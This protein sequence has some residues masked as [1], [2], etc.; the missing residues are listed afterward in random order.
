MRQWLDRFTDGRART[1]TIGVGAVLALALAGA[2]SAAAA[3][4]V[5]ENY[6]PFANCPVNDK[7]VDLCIVATTTSGEFAMGSKTVHIESP[8]VLEGGI[9][10]NGGTQELV[11]PTSGHTLESPPMKVPG[12]LVGVEGVGEE[13][14]ATTELVGPVF[15]NVG[16]QSSGEGTAVILPLRAKLNNAALGEECFIGSAAE[17]IL[18]HL[19]TGTTSPP[20]P[21]TP[22]TGSKGKA[23][24]HDEII[25]LSGS[26][27]VDNSFAAP[28]VNGCGGSLAPVLDPVVDLSAGLPS[29]SGHNTAVLNGTVMLAGKKFVKKAHVIKKPKKA[30]RA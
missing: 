14:T 13:V 22:I 25:T 29:A 19:T 12:G 30:K 21:N 4:V 20:P 9:S 7:A 2:P 23:T 28:G 27:L 26:S 11:P 10:N 6:K 18:L 3:P 24:D 1:V 5:D 8:V 16:A 17:P 15:V